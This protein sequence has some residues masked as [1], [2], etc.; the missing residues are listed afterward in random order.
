MPD[1]SYLG[2]EY[3]LGFG[4][5][6]IKGVGGVGFCLGASRG[7]EGVAFLGASRGRE[8]C[9]SRGIKGARGLPV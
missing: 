6:G 7:R 1:R 2:D 3:A 4:Y 9:L 5:R 8:G